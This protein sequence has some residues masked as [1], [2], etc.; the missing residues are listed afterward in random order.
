MKRRIG[1][2]RPRALGK[3]G[4]GVAPGTPTRAPSVVGINAGCASGGHNGRTGP[5]CE[6]LVMSGADACYAIGSDGGPLAQLVE[7]QTL[8]PYT[9][10][11]K[12][13]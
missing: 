9:A 7:Q 11:P 5:A 8:N 13:Q 12:T 3:K 2:R 6:A 10:K 1:R 4:C